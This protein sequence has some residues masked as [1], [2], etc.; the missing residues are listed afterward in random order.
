MNDVEDVSLHFRGHESAHG[1]EVWI[2]ADTPK[3]HP[4]WN[5]G[6]N[7]R[8]LNAADLRYD[9][10]VEFRLNTWS[11]DWPRI[12]KPFYF[13]RANHGMTL[14]LMF[15][16]LCS[17]RDQ[18]RFSLGKDDYLSW[19]GRNDGRGLSLLGLCRCRCRGRRV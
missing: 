9:D 11:Y 14:I 12:A 8:A 10:D 13:G 6:G 3:G 19:P 18:I 7:Y 1:P 15:D 17:D 16:R 2:A 4:D 5:G